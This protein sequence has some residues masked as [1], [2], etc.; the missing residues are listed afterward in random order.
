KEHL[1]PAIY[2]PK[3]CGEED[4]FIKD[5][6]SIVKTFSDF[7][8]QRCTEGF[9]N[10]L[11]AAGLGGITGASDFTKDNLK[12]FVAAGGMLPFKILLMK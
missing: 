6:K 10:G 12:K 11:K 5:D 7:S 1:D 8:K 2:D 9:F 4:V 3:I